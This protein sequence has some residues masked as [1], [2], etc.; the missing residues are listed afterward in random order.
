MIE[1]TVNE[2]KKKKLDEGF[3]A[4]K[5][6]AE[7]LLNDLQDEIADMIDKGGDS[8]DARMKQIYRDYSRSFH[9]DRQNNLL[10]NAKTVAQK[11]QLDKRTEFDTFITSKTVPDLVKNNK[12]ISSSMMTILT[13]I[14]KKFENVIKK[15]FPK[16]DPDSDDN[17]LQKYINELPCSVQVRKNGMMEVLPNLARLRARSIYAF[18]LALEAIE[19]DCDPKNPETEKRRITKEAVEKELSTFPEEVQQALKD[20]EKR[21]A[22]ET[23]WKAGIEAI[24]N[25]KELKEKYK[26]YDEETKR[27][28]KE[29]KKTSGRTKTAKF[30]KIAGEMIKE[31]LNGLFPNCDTRSANEKLQ[32]GVRKKI[33]LVINKD[34][35]KEKTN[36]GSFYKRVLKPY[37]TRIENVQRKSNRSIENNPKSYGGSELI[38][39]W[40]KKRG[41]R[42]SETLYYKLAAQN[43]ENYDDFFIAVTDK[44][45]IR[46]KV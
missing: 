36:V 8:T 27:M 19:I 14:K 22:S 17:P 13:D 10:K 30:K 43:I 35:F 29:G 44:S 12:E 3:E 11:T 5:D 42:K 39:Y 24:M 6:R 9:P 45:A 32:A 34:D 25:S 21:I 4:L 23:K 37:E 1:A 31:Y 15:E 41:S 18:V 2:I 16:H 28:E 20:P 26:A 46:F 38:M 7:A 33:Q 40:E